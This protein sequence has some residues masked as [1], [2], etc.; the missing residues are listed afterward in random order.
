MWNEWPVNGEK[1]YTPGG[2]TRA[3]PPETCIQWVKEAWASVSRET[4]LHS[5]KCAGITKDIDGA[6]DALM[7]CMKDESLAQE[8]KEQLYND[9]ETQP[10]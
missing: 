3:P 5:F 8:I 2:N 1:T 10:V 6:E 4:I 9:Q 7:T